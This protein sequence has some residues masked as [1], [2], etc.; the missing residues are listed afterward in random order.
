M[1]WESKIVVITGGLGQLGQNFSTAFL[2]KGARVVLLDLSDDSAR[3]NGENSTFFTAQKLFLYKADI[4]NRN[5]VER[6]ATLIEHSIGIPNVLVNNAALD[7]PPNAP[8]SENGPFEDYPLES[9]QK[10]FEVNVLGTVVCCQVFGK[11]MVFANEPASII[12]IAS[13][14]G[15]LSPVQD[16]YEYRRKNGAQWYKPVAYSITKSAVLNFTRYL[17]TYWAKKNIRV[18]TISPSGIFNNQD[19]EF[20]EEYTKRIPIGRMARPEEIAEAVLFLASDGS[21]YVTGSNLV[22]DGGWTAW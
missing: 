10:S 17:A 4:T 8:A 3:L 5:E 16:I 14:Y 12:N 21:S 7:S 1:T 9:I 22:V 18:N 13:I 2:R 15:M 11:K 19:S 20:L 6:I